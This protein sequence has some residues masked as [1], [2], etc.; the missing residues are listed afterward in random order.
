MG[1]KKVDTGDNMGEPQRKEKGGLLFEIEA[2]ELG[3][4]SNSQS[5]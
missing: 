3:S 4:K 5:R 2:R 1:P